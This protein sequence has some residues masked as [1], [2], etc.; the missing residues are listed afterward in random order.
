MSV[1]SALAPSSS[2]GPAPTTVPPFDQVSVAIAP[3]DDL[4]VRMPG[5]LLVVGVGPVELDGASA[6]STDIR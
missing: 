5:I 1:D 4:V 3:G 6:L 2:T